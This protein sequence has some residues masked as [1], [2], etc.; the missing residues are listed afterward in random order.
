M[1]HW[2]GL[3]R[4]WYSCLER[5]IA[6]LYRGM[7]AAAGVPEAHGFP[8]FQISARSPATLRAKGGR[9]SIVLHLL[10]VCILDVLLSFC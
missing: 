4:C 1:L 8:T 9:K 7:G 3:F 6:A 2:V 10:P 5:E